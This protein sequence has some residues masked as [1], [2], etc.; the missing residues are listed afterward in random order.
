M[1]RYFKDEGIVLRKKNLLNNDRLITILSKRKGKINLLGKGVRK[2]TSRRLSHLET[3][4]LIKFSFYKKDSYLYL[5]ET[6]LIYGYAKIKQNDRKINLLYLLFFIIN[7][8]VAENQKDEL[9]FKR[10][11]RMLKELNNQPSFGIKEAKT[12]LID[13]LFF[14]GFIDKK[15]L[16][17]ASFDPFDFIEGLIN[18]KIKKIMV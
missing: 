12:F 2:I 11:V 13:I 10:T 8:I 9:V 6:E 14:S 7:K 3:G 16:E 1:V 5:R 18:Q 15:L 17:N 4:N